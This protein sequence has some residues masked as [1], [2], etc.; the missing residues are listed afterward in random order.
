MLKKFKTFLYVL[1]Q[2]FNP[3][4]YHEV[5]K[6]K[7]SFSFKFFVFFFL[8]LNIIQASAIS[9]FLSQQLKP[10]I[11]KA[12]TEI[13]NLYPAD[14]NLTINNGVVATNVNEPYF[15][16]IN[17]DWF[18]Q[19]LKQALQNQP[20]Q[21]IMV[22]DTKALPTDISK[23]Q[24]FGLLTKDSLTVQTQDETRIRSLNN[25]TAVQL[26]KQVV[27]EALKKIVPYFNW[28]TPLIIVTLFIFLPI[29]IILIKF[30]SLIIF[31][32]I[33]WL[34]AKLF[35]L[36][37]TYA[38]SLQLNLHAIVV[39][40]FI[41]LLFELLGVSPKIPSFESLILLIFNL[42]ILASLKEK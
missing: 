24:T 18:P 2:S 36:K 32:I 8:F 34:T 29:F 27:D 9:I 31:S 15:I 5:V 30:F 1:R 12:K 26:N 20:I 14:L 21:N 10:I 39:P 13:F 37:L 23:Y 17:P 6:T 35:K 4:Y 41:I 19:D 25:I 7:F 38:K 33:T 28:I 22:I 16:P 40:T 11:A 42:I 3:N